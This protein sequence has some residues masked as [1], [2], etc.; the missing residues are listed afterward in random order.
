MNLKISKIGAVALL[1]IVLGGG[2]SLN[3]LYLASTNLENSEKLR[4][5]MTKAEVLKLMGPP[6]ADETFNTPDHWFYYAFPQWHDGLVTEDEC[7]PLVFADGKLIG[8]G[9]D[10]YTKFQLRRNPAQKKP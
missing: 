10:F 1:A 8:W 7:L 2:C 9:V 6:E 5:G 3:P 4:V